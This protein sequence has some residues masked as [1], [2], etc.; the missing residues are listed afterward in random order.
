MQQ[1]LKNWVSIYKRN[2]LDTKLCIIDQNG[3]KRIK[4]L[5]IRSKT[6]KLLEENRKCFETLG[7]E[8]ILG[9]DT[10]ST[11]KITKQKSTNINKWGWH[12]TENLLSFRGR[13]RWWRSK[14]G[15]LGQPPHKYTKTHQ[16]WNNSYEATDTAEDSRPPGG[17]AK[18]PG[19]R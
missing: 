8:Q 16:G 5:N 10:K 17:Q 13:K 19:M 15:R 11:R 9:Y 3:S 6:S 4:D 14:T 2:N 18:L 7:L 1:H 12:Q